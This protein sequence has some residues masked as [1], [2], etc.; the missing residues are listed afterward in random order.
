MLVFVSTRVAA[1]TLSQSVARLGHSAEYLHGDMHQPQRME[2]GQAACGLRN[3][4]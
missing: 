2:V 3:S 1:E 4:V